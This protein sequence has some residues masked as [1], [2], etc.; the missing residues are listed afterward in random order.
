MQEVEE[1]TAPNHGMAIGDLVLCRA[2]RYARWSPSGERIP[3]SWRKSCFSL[4]VSLLSRVRI[5]CETDCSAATIADTDE[6]F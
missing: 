3:S 6:K 4:F 1:G 2:S 5:S